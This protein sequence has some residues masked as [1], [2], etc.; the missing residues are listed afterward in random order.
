MIFNGN[1]NW[2]FV[3]CWVLFE[4]LKGEKG[5]KERDS[6]RKLMGEREK[7]RKVIKVEGE[8]DNR[9]KRVKEEE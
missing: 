4:I 8:R 7:G 9:D 6:D 2:N 1:L 3:L 5:R